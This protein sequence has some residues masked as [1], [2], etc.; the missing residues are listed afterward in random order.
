MWA[1]CRFHHGITREEFAELRPV[2]F[3]AL[4]T[5]RSVEIAHQRYN[6]GLVA[7]ILVNSQIK[8]KGEPISPFDFIPGFDKSPL[9]K[10]NE[11]RRNGAKQIVQTVLGRM[12]DA[13]PEDVAKKRVE[14]VE[15]FRKRGL[16]D[17]EGIIH[18]VFPGL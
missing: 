7:A 5:R 18:E 10:A 8:S 11:E 12:H 2:E 1:L 3:E 13:T 16:E 9:E 15:H 6:A 14:L 4:E 17:P